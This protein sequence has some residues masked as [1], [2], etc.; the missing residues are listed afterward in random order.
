MPCNVRDGNQLNAPVCIL[1][2]DPPKVFV[3][4]KYLTGSQLRKRYFGGILKRG[5]W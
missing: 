5:D 1:A 2:D 4:H 3:L